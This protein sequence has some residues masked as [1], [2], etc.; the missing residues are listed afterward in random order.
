MKE[1]GALDSHGTNSASSVL[2]FFARNVQSAVGQRPAARNI[3]LIVAAA[4]LCFGVAVY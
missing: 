2:E 1:T 4:A 3:V